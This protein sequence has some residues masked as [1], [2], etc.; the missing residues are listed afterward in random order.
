MED[1]GGGAPVPPPPPL[2]AQL[3]W[4]QMLLGFVFVLSGVA[5]SFRIATRVAL[6]RKHQEPSALVAQAPMPPLQPAMPPEAQHEPP[7]EREHL[8][9]RPPPRP[10]PPSPRPSPAPAP[11]PPPPTPPPKPPP[12]LG[13]RKFRPRGP[14]PPSPLP[15]PPLP[16]A[17]PM[18]PPSP[19][20][21]PPPSPSP[22]TP[23][24]PLNDAALVADLN[25]RFAHGGARA[26]THGGD[27]RHAGVLVHTFGGLEDPNY[28]WRPCPQHSWCKDVGN[29]LSATPVNG[30]ARALVR[31]SR[32]GVVL[33]PS[34]RL[35]CA[36]ARDGNSMH[37]SKSCHYTPTRRTPPAPPPFDAPNR[38]PPPRLRRRGRAMRRTTTTF[39]RTSR[40]VATRARERVTRAKMPRR[41]SRPCKRRRRRRPSRTPRRRQEESGGRGRGRR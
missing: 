37:S 8:H 2:Y 11:P 15:P 39:G 23:P 26:M 20:S 32:G 35:L 16:P 28:P 19:P 13:W 1:G 29:R 22:T 41:I 40:T 9:H 31:G 3:N 6:M 4:K 25:A 30:A 27:L 34:V 21:P 5:L 17:P 36:Y 7:H 18:P 38:P 14:P 10:P 12:I 33:H 24:P